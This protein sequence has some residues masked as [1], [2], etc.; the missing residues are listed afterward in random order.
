MKSIKVAT[1]NVDGLPEKL[2]LFDLPWILRPLA[3][4]YKLIKGTTEI[5]IND[6][7]GKSE[8]T[9]KIGEYLCS[10]NSDIIGLQEDFNY[11]GE[12]VKPLSSIY[13]FGTHLGG[14][15]LS[16][17]FS[18]TEWFSHFP[19]PRFR[20]DG[21]SIIVRNRIKILGEEIVRWKKSYGYV[22]HAND[23][24]T[25]KGFRYYPL[26]IDDEVSVDVYIL[27]LDADFYNP[28]TCPDVSKDIEARESQLQQ[29]V[30]YI[31]NRG[32]NN[33]VI[34]MGDMNSSSRY[35]WD[36]EN[37]KKNLL[38]PINDAQG[39]T[40][41]QVLPDD[42]YTIPDVD[43]IYYINNS[44]LKN[45]IRPIECLY[46]TELRNLSDHT[47]LIARFIISDI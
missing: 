38:D 1:Y 9:R 29:L 39:L 33:P 11:H 7:Q 8:C 47:P 44:R 46:D 45:Q 41:K 28:E 43:R 19:L 3:W 32:V 37:I 40:I 23:L 24:L 4:I 18:R 27:H 36:N 21:L 2:D 15:S 12:L 26:L 6:N 31:M 30:S 42:D 5:T 14:F 10:S 17:L 34:V 16:D 13:K 25:H 20:C 35:S 22:G